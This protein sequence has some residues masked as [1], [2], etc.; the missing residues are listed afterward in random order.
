M[1]LFKRG[2]LLAFLGAIFVTMPLQA[3]TSHKPAQKASSKTSSA[4]P[5]KKSTRAASPRSSAKKA[6]PK[7]SGASNCRTVRVKTAKGYVNRRTCKAATEAAEPR[8]LTSPIPE[9]ALTRT[10]PATNEP[11][12]ARTVPD[13]A[14]AV[15][16]QTFFYQGR[17]YRV[18]GLKGNDNSDMAKQRLQRSLES[19]TLN[20]SP[21]RTDESGVATATVRVNGRDIADDTPGGGEHRPLK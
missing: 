11:V 14:Y 21:L 13:R 4:K 20:V 17:K 12:K 9:N 6:A 10:A 7:A 3:A 5:A 18:A 16:G 2:L 19:G 1:S 8:S 15:D